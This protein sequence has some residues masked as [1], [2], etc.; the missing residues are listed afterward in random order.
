MPVTRARS[1]DT[2]A[3]VRATTLENC[4]YADP[5]RRISRR[6]NCEPAARYSRIKVK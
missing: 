1:G 2:I 4:F 6:E 5:P 3:A